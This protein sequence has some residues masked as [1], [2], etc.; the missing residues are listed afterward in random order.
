LQPDSIISA[1]FPLKEVQ[2]A[3]NLLEQEPENYI[4][5]LLKIS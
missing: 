1:E 2:Y 4:K 5:V 3:F